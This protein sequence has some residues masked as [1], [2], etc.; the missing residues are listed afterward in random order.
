MRG[1]AQWGRGKCW[2]K[3]LASPQFR[4]QQKSLL[5][6]LSHF[7]SHHSNCMYDRETNDGGRAG[8]Q[9]RQISAIEKHCNIK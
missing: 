8:E 3:V 9:A 2:L 6:D 5:N 1:E 7:L 4:V